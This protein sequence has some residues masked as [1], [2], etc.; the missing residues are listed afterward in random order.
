MS[1]K[2]E[3]VLK[4]GCSSMNSSFNTETIFNGA[5]INNTTISNNYFQL[6]ADEKYQKMKLHL[7]KIVDLAV[8][9]KEVFPNDNK[10]LELI[11]KYLSIVD[12]FNCTLVCKR[13]NY[14]VSEMNCFHL[15]PNLSSKFRV[16]PRLS[17]KYKKVTIYGY[18]C[19]R[20]Q[21]PMHRMLEHLSHSVINLK[22]EFCIF[23]L[24]TLS[25]IVGKLPLLESLEM[26][27]ILTLKEDI[28][29]FWEDI[30]K[31]LHL[32]FLKIYVNGDLLEELLNMLGA[33]SNVQT[34][35]L[36]DATIETKVFRRVKQFQRSLR[37]LSFTRCIID[38]T[39]L[40]SSLNTLHFNSIQNIQLNDYSCL[41]NLR[42]LHLIDCEVSNILDFNEFLRLSEFKVG[43]TPKYTDIITKNKVMSMF[44]THYQIIKYFCNPINSIIWEINFSRFIALLQLNYVR[45]IYFIYQNTEPIDNKPC[46]IYIWCETSSNE[47]PISFRTN[48]LED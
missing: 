17:R 26:K 46:N 6:S 38:E 7:P 1:E 12:K 14:L 32:Q 45:S 34:L 2:L 3:I 24:I 15:V 4:P 36:S 20:L 44:I 22:L 18:Q 5:A 40:L 35:S 13:F 29:L 10:V 42:V 37:S 25:E 33:A 41:Q 28:E 39:G 11:W 31:P 30:P 8:F 43:F 23:N 19:N 27:I 9:S 16:F 21:E 47:E 48:I